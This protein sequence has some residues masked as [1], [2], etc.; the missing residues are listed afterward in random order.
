MAIRLRETSNR[1]T[2]SSHRFAVGQTVRLRSTFGLSPRTAE[3]Y[4][5]TGRLP[6]KD[7][8]PQYRVRSDQERHERV[9]TEDDLEAMP[10]LD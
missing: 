8:S 3:V 10:I 5:I 6:E 2:M 7:R 1:L 4:R 9:L